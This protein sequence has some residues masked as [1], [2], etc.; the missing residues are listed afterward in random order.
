MALEKCGVVKPGVTPVTDE[1]QADMIKKAM[2]NCR[3]CSRGFE[4]E[5]VVKLEDDPVKRLADKVANS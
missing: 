4:E 2:R 5:E 3:Y 1:E